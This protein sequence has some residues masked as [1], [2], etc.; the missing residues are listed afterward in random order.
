MQVLSRET[1]GLK[2]QEFMNTHYDPRVVVG[3]NFGT[4]YA[5]LETWDDNAS[6]YRLFAANARRR[7]NSIVH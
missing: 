5:L 1:L 6:Y 4:P 2:I 7:W 3:G